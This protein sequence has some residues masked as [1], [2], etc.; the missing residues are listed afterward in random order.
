M[1]KIT[2][3]DD[4]GASV[5]RGALAASSRLSPA[6][7][8]IVSRDIGVGIGALEQFA[9]GTGKL[10]AE[11]LVKLAVIVFEGHAVYDPA[12][13]KLRSAHRHEPRPLGRAPDPFPRPAVPAPTFSGG[14]YPAAKCGASP[15]AVVPRRPGWEA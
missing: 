13:D 15:P 5:L 4:S 10:S 9:T 8:K 7:A 3:N 6:Y 11:A 12:T 2:A 14:Y 1:T